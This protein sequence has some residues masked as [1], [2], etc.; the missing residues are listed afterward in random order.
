MVILIDYAASY[1]SV[2]IEIPFDVS[3]RLHS[4]GVLLIG[5]DL[6]FER[7]RKVVNPFE[8]H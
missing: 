4:P 1:L 6:E 5:I 2:D 7:F 3:Y 8:I